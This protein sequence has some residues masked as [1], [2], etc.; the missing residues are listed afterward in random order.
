MIRSAGP[1]SEV[2]RKREPVEKEKDI[3]L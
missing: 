3:V 1:E 2:R